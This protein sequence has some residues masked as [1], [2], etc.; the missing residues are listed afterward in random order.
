MEGD[1]A[2]VAEF[3]PPGGSIFD[4]LEG[5]DGP[6]MMRMLVI[7]GLFEAL[8][9]QGWASLKV[10]MVLIIVVSFSFIAGDFRQFMKQRGDNIYTQI[11]LTRAATFEDIEYAMAQ[12]EAC[13][14]FEPECEDKKKKGKIYKMNVDTLND[15]F[16]VLKNSKTRSIYDKTE[17][18]VTKKNLKKAPTDGMRYFDAF[19]ELKNYAIFVILTLML[20]Q[21]H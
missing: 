20:V 3:G 12:Y 5:K 19:A 2:Q 18:F 7:Q 1:E 10:K 6:P 13:V 16:F 4:N 15:I 14:N 9:K 8:S 17:Q 21:K 11:G